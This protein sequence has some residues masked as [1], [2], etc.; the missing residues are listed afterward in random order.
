MYLTA[1]AIRRFPSVPVGIGR[2][3]CE[4]RLGIEEDER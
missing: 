1:V 4:E 2:Q 3:V